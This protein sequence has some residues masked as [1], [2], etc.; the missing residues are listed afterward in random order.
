MKKYIRYVFGVAILV[1]ILNKFYLR[2]WILS[3]Y[4]SDLLT[5]FTLSVP[6]LIEA[7]IGTLILTGILFQLRHYFKDKLG[8]FEDIHTST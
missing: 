5:M 2:P 1:F 7:I 4:V 3:H 6:N 8:A